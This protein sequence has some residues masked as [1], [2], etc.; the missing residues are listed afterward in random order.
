MIEIGDY[1]LIPTKGQSK[2]D[3]LEQRSKGIGGSDM[4]VL[5]NMNEW[6]SSTELF[7]E[8]LGRTEPKNLSENAAIYYGT[9]FED[10]ILE[11]SQYLNPNGPENN[12][13]KNYDDGKKLASHVPFPY[14]VVNKKFPW[15]IS[16]V[17]GLGFKDKSI[18]EQDV[19]NQVERGEMPVPDYIVEIKTMDAFARDKYKTGLNPSYPIQVKTYCTAFLDLNSDIYGMIYAFCFD[20]TLTAH[21]IPLEQ[22]DIVSILEASKKFDVLIDQG[23]KIISEGYKSKLSEDEIDQN[24]SQIHPEPKTSVSSYGKFLSERFLQKEYIAKNQTFK[25]SDEDIALGL[26]MNQINKEK[27]ELEKEK[28]TISNQIKAKLVKEKSKVIDCGKR[29]KLSYGKRLTNSIK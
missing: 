12:H 8:K 27:K 9:R 24:L 14:M 15:I 4:A 7:Y 19:I 17:D 29:G 6:Y 23:K 25:G 18:T 10:I 16:N 13:I 2:K 26:R 3:W 11:D 1:L 22:N 21:H 20:K 5:F 28:A